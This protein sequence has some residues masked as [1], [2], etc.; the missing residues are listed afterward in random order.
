MRKVAL[1]EV[2]QIN[3]KWESELGLDG[4]ISFVGMADLSD[5]LGR[6]VREEK[7]CVRQVR[8]G[9]TPFARGD[10]LVAKITPCFENGKIGLASINEE[11]GAGSTEFHVV[12][13]GPELDARYALHY[14][15]RPEFRASGELRMTGSGGQ[16]R[17]PPGYV[18]DAKIPLPPLIEQWRIADI[19]DKADALRAKRRETIA[20]LDS[21]GQAIFHEMFAGQAATFVRLDDVLTSGLRNGLSPSKSGKTMGEVLTLGAITGP[22]LDL[23]HKKSAMFDSAF[24]CE[25]LLAP[26]KILICRGNGNRRLVGR[27][28]IVGP[29]VEIPHGLA[30]PDTIIAGDVNLERVSPA[31]L[32]FIWDG[33]G[34]RKQIEVGATTTN[35][36]YKVNQRLLSSIRF[37][38]PS[39]DLQQQFAIKVQLI[40]LQRERLSG[41]LHELDN[42]FLSLQDRAFKGEL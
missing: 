29:E 9:Y 36:T 1:S 4:P 25:Q 27:A 32:R 5:E 14:L 7:R 3:P 13:T 39:W 28:K 37:P 16:R 6:V 22:R 41:E 8:K 34:V 17:V 21:L 24:H 40:E 23:S 12:R 20:L 30:Y 33:S 38:L 2:A 31:F 35:G 18:S 19:L 26:G 42:L 11:Y 15:R 10:L